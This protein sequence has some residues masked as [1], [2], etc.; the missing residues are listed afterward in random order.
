MVVYHWTDYNLRSG[1]GNHMVITSGAPPTRPELAQAA[2][3][4]MRGLPKGMKT[5]QVGTS[6]IDCPEPI[7]AAARKP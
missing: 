1:P 7:K 5:A 4:I 3:E 2:E 6:R